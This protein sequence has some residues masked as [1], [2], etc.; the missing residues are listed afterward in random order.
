VVIIGTGAG[1]T[2][3]DASPLRSPQSSFSDR[4]FEVA[5]FASLEL[6]DLTVTGGRAPAGSGTNQQH[7]GAI[8]VRN[9]GLLTVENSAIV[10]NEANTSTGNGGAIYFENYSGGYIR[11]S[12]ITGNRAGN[13]TGG[14]Y[15]E[16][17]QPP[18]SSVVVGR[19]IIVDNTD[20]LTTSVDDVFAGA[21]RSFSTEGNNRLGNAGYG[22]TN[23][24]NGDYVG[25]PLYVVTGLADTFNSADDA[26]VRSVRE[27]VHAANGV[28]GTKEIWLPA[29]NFKLTRERSLAPPDVTTDMT[30]EYGDLDVIQRLTVRGVDGSTSVAWRSGAVADKVFELVGDY[31]LNGIVDTADYVLWQT[32][33]GDDDG[34]T[35]GDQGDY[36]A[37]ANHY[38]NT[39]E[40]L[41]VA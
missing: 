34:V 40:L 6:R 11:N 9:A 10:D 39:L 1:E 35:G 30:A 7:G 3:I 19:T 41:G 38:D 37:W 5:N 32:N 8:L 36:D 23:G 24:Q 26:R 25:N 2:V 28:S 29:W 12:V 14:V 17:Q 13:S 4:V 27:A 31:N 18:V 21:Y 15:L 20:N 33:D 16:G 22:F